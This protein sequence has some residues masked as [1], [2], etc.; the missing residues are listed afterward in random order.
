MTS[1]G[2]AK[3]RLGEDDQEKVRGTTSNG[4][5]RG[6]VRL[7]M[8]VNTKLRPVW[9]LGQRRM[10]VRLDLLRRLSL[11]SELEPVFQDVVYGQLSATRA[12]E[13]AQKTAERKTD[14]R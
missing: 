6:T 14:D 9:G 2:D 12:K 10:E 7:R 11:P 4:K 1:Y 5:R 13:H 8:T 3:A